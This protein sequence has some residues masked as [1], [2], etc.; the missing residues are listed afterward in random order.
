MQD[1]TDRFGLGRVCDTRNPIEFAQTIRDITDGTQMHCLS[2]RSREF[3]EFHS[4]SNF[5]SQITERIAQRMAS[6]TS[7]AMF[8]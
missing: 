2:D 8:A 7:S 1:V 5:Q 4:L 3:V 6:G